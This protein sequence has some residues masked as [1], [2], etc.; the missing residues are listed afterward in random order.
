MPRQTSARVFSS[1]FK[2]AVVKGEGDGSGAVHAA[3]PRARVLGEERR[4]RRERPGVVVVELVPNEYAPA[5]HLDDL[6]D[7]DRVVA[8]QS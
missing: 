8:E 2:V 1:E 6:D 7:V 4:I 5:R 3:S